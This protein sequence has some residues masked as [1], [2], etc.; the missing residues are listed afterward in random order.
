MH[1]KEIASARSAYLSDSDEYMRIMK[2]KKANT[3]VLRSNNPPK[4]AHMYHNIQNYCVL[5]MKAVIPE[6]KYM[7]HSA[8]DCTGVCTNR[9]IKDVMG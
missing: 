7:S 3:G 1:I 6:R 4:E 2:K 8:K 9:S 5:C